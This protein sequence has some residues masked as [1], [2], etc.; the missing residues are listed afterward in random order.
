MQDTV[1]VDI[2]YINKISHLLLKFHQKES[3]LWNFRCPICGDSKKN[4]NKARGYIFRGEN[5]QLGFT[6]KN[7]DVGGPISRLIEAT[8]PALHSQYIVDAFMGQS[9]QKPQKGFTVPSY[10]NPSIDSLSRLDYMVDNHEAVR[11]V[12]NRKIPREELARFYYCED[13]SSWVETNS[14]TH[15]DKFP[16]KEARIIIPFWDRTGTQLTSIQGR[17]LP[18]SKSELR[19]ATIRLDETVPKVYGLEKVNIGQSVRIVE[20]PI[21][22]VF[23][24]NC[25][26]TA[27][28]NLVNK[29]ILDYIGVHKDR[30]VLIFDNEPDNKFTKKRIEKAVADDYSVM[31][32]PKWIKSKDINQTVIDYK[33]GTK[34][35]D[36]LI[37]S[38]TFKGLQAQMILNEW[39]Q[40]SFGRK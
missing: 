15:A 10:V 6:C 11:Y 26:A 7:C 25:I 18:S 21:D 20:G 23:I 17:A 31:I 40:P 30:I 38:H 22:S 36:A 13:F 37:K 34:E 35:V 2:E 19:Y 29:R 28:G 9:R 8:D 12:L 16:N 33:I 5:G 14:P 27:D 1:A 3:Y 4:L 39:S 24:D 32:W